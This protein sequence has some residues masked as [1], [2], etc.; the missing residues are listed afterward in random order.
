MCGLYNLRRRTRFHPPD[1]ESRSR[2]RRS[3]KCHR[4]IT[5][6]H[7][8][9]TAIDGSAWREVAFKVDIIDTVDEARGYGGHWS[10]RVRG[11]MK[12]N[13]PRLKVSYTNHFVRQIELSHLGQPNEVLTWLKII[14]SPNR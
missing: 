2:C 3:S 12:V 4:A 7:V 5:A 9:R 8:G 14:R 6:R 1:C 10:Y 13:R 11:G